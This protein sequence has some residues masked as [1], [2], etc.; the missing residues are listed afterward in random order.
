VKTRIAA[1]FICSVLLVAGC[2][3]SNDQGAAR[4]K[5][6]TGATESLQLLTP[7]EF[8]AYMEAKPDV[9]V[10]NV[11]I[12]YEGHIDG[13]DS[14]VPFDQI[15]EWEGLPADKSQPI[16]LYCRSGRMSA[17]ATQALSNRGYTSIVDLAGGMKA[18][19][20]AGFPLETTEP[21]DTAGGN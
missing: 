8:K 19:E 2:S 1:A 7:Q 18:W 11:H 20:S 15:T 17:E 10:V 12:P 13:T 6:V 4:D 14:F 21:P 16:V 3:S 5:P 9:P